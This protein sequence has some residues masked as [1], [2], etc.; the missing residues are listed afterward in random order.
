MHKDCKITGLLCQRHA[1]LPS[2]TCCGKPRQCALRVNIQP[3]G[4]SCLPHVSDCLE[5]AQVS[6]ETSCLKTSSGS[7]FQGQ[8]VRQA[9]VQICA[10]KKSTADIVA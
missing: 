9:D 3:Y 1:V 7:G 6:V 10:N 2:Y 5:D 4:R 8:N